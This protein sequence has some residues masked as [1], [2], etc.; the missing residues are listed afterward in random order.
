RGRNSPP[1]IFQKELSGG[2]MA[3]QLI[4]QSP[5]A[6]ARA[7]GE[8]SASRD[9]KEDSFR[10][11]G[12]N[13]LFYDLP[14]DYKVYAFYYPSAMGDPELEQRLRD[15]GRITGQNLLVNIGG[16]NDPQLG[17]IQTLFGIRNYPVIVVT[18]LSDLASPANEY[19]TA[20][21]RLDSKHLLNSAVRT[22]E[23]V[24]KLFN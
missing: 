14:L 3:F 11:I 5:A 10:D 4:L 24:E 22:V 6:K 7:V 18:A 20:Y 12:E 21:A 19:F 13:V 8:G 15:L 1:F 2:H 23:C 17:R 16:L 9:I